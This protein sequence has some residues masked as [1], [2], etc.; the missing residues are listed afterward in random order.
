MKIL[1]AL[2]ANTF[3]KTIRL[4]DNRNIKQ[5]KDLLFNKDCFAKQGKMIDKLA[6]IK[7][8]KP[9]NTK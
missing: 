5:M 1:K 2:L 8:R 3:G 4:L 6:T 9:K 7:I